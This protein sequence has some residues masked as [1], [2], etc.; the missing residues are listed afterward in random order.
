MTS[1]Q[2]FTL[3]DGRTLG[4]ATF[5]DPTGD[6]L[7]FHHGTPGCHELGA[8]LDGPATERGVSVVAPGRPGSGQSD[9]SPGAGIGEWVGDYEAL[10]DHLDVA[11]APVVGFS[12]GCP[13]A[14]G[15]AAHRPARVSHL[16]L[17]GGPVPNAE[18][19]PFGPLTR[20][21]RLLGATLRTVAWLAGHVG[22]GVVT[23]SL[24][25]RDLDDE[26]ART[27][28]LD[29]RRAVAGGATGPVR[30]TRFL[31]GDWELPAVEVPTTVYHGRSDGNVPVGPVRAYWSGRDGV[32][33][34]ELDS[35]HLGS[36][37]EARQDVLAAAVEDP[38]PTTG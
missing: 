3:P 34:R 29:F 7:V 15:V 21:P 18:S 9:P 31:A 1:I 28:S 27:V 12:G 32:T 5:G 30:E 20:T 11:S 38:V 36:F 16:A 22:P 37:L 35:D 4:V 26:V 13:F 8:L 24:T 10:V 6:P 19:D 14:A 33:V 17:I 23:G 2:S 25:E